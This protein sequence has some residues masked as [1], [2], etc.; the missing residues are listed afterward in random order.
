MASEQMKTHGARTPITQTQQQ[1]QRER[2]G[3]FAGSALRFYF[4]E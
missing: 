1:Q 3:E 2:D 4:Y